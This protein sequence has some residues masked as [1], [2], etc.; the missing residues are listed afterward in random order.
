M[1]HFL[2][3]MPSP[4]PPQPHNWSGQGFVTKPGQSD[5]FPENLYMAAGR[6]YS[7]CGHGA[8]RTGV[9][10]CWALWCVDSWP[11][12]VGPPVQEQQ[13]R[14]LEGEGETEQERGGERRGLTEFEALVKPSLLSLTQ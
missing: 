6:V 13:R 2:Y 8:V 10:I 12:R 1:G 9:Q 3:P 7:L 14:E 11:E 4:P 5:A